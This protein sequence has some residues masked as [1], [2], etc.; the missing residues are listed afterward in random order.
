MVWH[1][2]PGWTCLVTSLLGRVR[3]AVAFWEPL[4]G[5][6]QW[7][8]APHPA[9]WASGTCL[10]LPLMRK[11]P[12]TTGTVTKPLDR[13]WLVDQRRLPSYDLGWGPFPAPEIH[14]LE[15]HDLD[16]DLETCD[17]D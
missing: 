11:E 10:L 4:P 16:H 7:L 1:L 15:V 6:E 13:G 5:C 14:D 9:C 3:R 8:E 12:G 17:P 2:E